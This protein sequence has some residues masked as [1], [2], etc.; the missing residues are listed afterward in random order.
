M[1]SLDYTYQF[2]VLR[3]FLHEFVKRADQWLGG[4]VVKRAAQWLAKKCG[5]V[6]RGV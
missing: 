4:G 2:F 1:K 5:R 3:M 6:Q